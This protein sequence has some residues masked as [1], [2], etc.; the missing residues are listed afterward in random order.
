M[1]RL[2]LLA[3]YIRG[4][5]EYPVFEVRHGMF[6]LITYDETETAL[7]GNVSG[8]WLNN[9]CQ[10]CNNGC[11]IQSLNVIWM[12]QNAGSKRHPGKS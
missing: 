7:E 5:D 1:S 12:Q 3:R 4:F 11:R 10:L 9:A 2:S 6:A 8:R